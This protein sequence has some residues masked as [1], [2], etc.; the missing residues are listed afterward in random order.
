MGQSGPLAGHKKE[1]VPQLE[2]FAINDG[3]DARLR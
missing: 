3:V 1:S 2:V